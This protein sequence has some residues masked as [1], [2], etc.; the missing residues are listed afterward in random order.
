MRELR[1]KEREIERLKE[2]GIYREP[3]NV[4][5]ISH[6]KDEGC[7]ICLFYNNCMLIKSICIR[8]SKT[9]PIN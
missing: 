9:R 8:N 7:C 6:N 4:L 1:E 3:E 5:F 2:R